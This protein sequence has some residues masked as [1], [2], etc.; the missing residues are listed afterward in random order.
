MGLAYNDS[1][2]LDTNYIKF[3]VTKIISI[4]LRYKKIMKHMQCVINSFMQFCM[5]LRFY[6][7][8]ST[9]F[10]MDTCTIVQYFAVSEL[11]AVGFYNLTE[12]AYLSI[13]LMY[14]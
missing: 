11:M 3:D 12:N 1:K 2:D 6:I 13:V 5:V 10:R 4:L 9:F 7:N 8:F 14:F